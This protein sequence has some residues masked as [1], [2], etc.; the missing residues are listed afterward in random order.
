MN[1]VKH[2]L[3]LALTLTM[4]LGA[5]AQNNNTVPVT[6]DNNLD[7][8]FT[9]PDYDAQV[10]VEYYN[11]YVLTLASNGSGVVVFSGDTLPQ[12]VTAVPG[13]TANT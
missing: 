4:S 11:G 13:S 8:N 6:Q 10:D 5:W 9:M 2:F 12:G 7:W 3:I 1:S